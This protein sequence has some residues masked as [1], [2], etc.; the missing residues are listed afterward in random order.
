MNLLN[1]IEEIEKVDPEFNERISPRRAAI[2]NI[3]GIFSK[4]ALTTLPV[5]LGSLLQKS[6]WT[7]TTCRCERHFKFCINTGVPGS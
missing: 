1:I 4:I 2:K 3:T 6:I 7:N 5:A